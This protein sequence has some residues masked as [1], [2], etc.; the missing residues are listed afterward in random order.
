[1]AFLRL[2][3]FRSCDRDSLM[4]PLLQYIGKTTTCCALLSGLKERFSQVGYMKP[5]GQVDAKVI[6]SSGEI[7][8]V[9]KDVRLFKE[10]FNLKH[11][12]YHDMRCVLG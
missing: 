12:S 8:K 3:H 6:G 7:I 5:V 11:C 9:D 4:L 2:V 1:M 10:F